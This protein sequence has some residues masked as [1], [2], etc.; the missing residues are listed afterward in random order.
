ML[1]QG[2]HRHL[3]QLDGLDLERRE[4]LLKLLF[5]SLSPW[6]RMP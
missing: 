2:L 6:D 4:L 1:L 5:K 3:D